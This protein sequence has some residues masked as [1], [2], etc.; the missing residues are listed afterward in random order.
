MYL[1]TNGHL[2]Q[3]VIFLGKIPKI[4]LYV[5]GMKLFMAVTIY[6]LRSIYN[7]LAE[8][9]TTSRSLILLICNMGITVPVLVHKLKR[10]HKSKCL[11]SCKALYHLG[12][13]Y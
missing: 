1:H 2:I 12:D 7:L 10:L 9:I 6:G 11:E 13:G 5:K 3:L 4:G 8:E